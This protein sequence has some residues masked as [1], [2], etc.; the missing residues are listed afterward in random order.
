MVKTSDYIPSDA[1]QINIFLFISLYYI[2][3]KLIQEYRENIISALLICF[4]MNPL[5][6]VPWY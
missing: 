2:I 5:F 3:Y 4:M 1:Y 6:I